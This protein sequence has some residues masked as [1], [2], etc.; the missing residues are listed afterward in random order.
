MITGMRKKLPLPASHQL[1]VKEGNQEHYS[2]R[3]GQTAVLVGPFHNVT[4]LP[5][6]A[7]AGVCKNVLYYFVIVLTL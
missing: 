2:F 6:L 1:Y 5:T 3:G 4:I 7:L